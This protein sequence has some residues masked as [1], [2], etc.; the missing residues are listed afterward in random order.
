MPEAYTAA[1]HDLYTG[2][3]AAPW[4][5]DDLEPASFGSAGDHI[6]LARLSP[7]QANATGV[8][9]G[10]G[11][12]SKIPFGDDLAGTLFNLGWC[13]PAMTDPACSA[14]GPTWPR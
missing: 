11:E 4:P 7:A 13:R 2:D 12:V 9:P 1:I 6:A 10:G 14:S 5:W 8:G 3:A